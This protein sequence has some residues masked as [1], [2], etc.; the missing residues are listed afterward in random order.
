MIVLANTLIGYDVV[1]FDS[2]LTPHYIAKLEQKL[3]NVTF[4]RVDSDTIDNLIKKDVEVPSKLSDE[5]KET[6]KPIFEGVVNKE[7]FT[8]QME[9]MSETDAPVVITQPEFMRRMQE[10]QRMGGGGM[11]GAFPEMYNFVVNVNHPVV[12]AVLAKEGEAKNDAAKQ[13][14]DLALL[15]QGMLKGENLTNFISRSVELM[16]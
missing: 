14:A 6:L 11:M 8:V 15:S 7:K 3:E 12:G 16:K 10:Q 1:L 13:L 5:E 9:S 2:P 4:V